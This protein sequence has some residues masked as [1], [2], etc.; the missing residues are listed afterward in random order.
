MMD[1]EKETQTESNI[2]TVSQWRRPL[3][4]AVEEV[5]ADAKKKQE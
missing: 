3:V 5:K 2:A 1:E 4:G